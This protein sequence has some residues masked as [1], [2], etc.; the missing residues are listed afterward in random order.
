[1]LE[2]AD[3]QEALELVKEAFDISERFDTPVIVRT[4]TRISHSRSLVKIGKR[5]PLAERKYSKNAQKYV[6]I[7]AYARIRHDVLLKRWMDLENFCEDGR[8]HEIYIPQGKN[9]VND[10]GIITSGVSFQYCRE[11]FTEVPIL[12]LKMTSPLPKKTIKQFCT[13][14]RLL[15]VV[16]ELEPYLEEQ[17]RLL[18]TGVQVAGKEYFPYYSWLPY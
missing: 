4:T 8:F 12:K 18:N 15:L 13:G 11:V 3:S 7:P 10:I 16:E 14:K 9:T 5:A 6:M 2:P 17:L 1:M